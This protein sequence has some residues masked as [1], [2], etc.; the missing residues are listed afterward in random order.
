[1]EEVALVVGGEGAPEGF[2]LKAP[3]FDD[4]GEGAEAVFLGVEAVLEK[5]AVGSADG[6]ARAGDGGQAVAGEGGDE[7]GVAE[8]D[9]EGIDGVAPL[10]LDEDFGGYAEGLAKE[11]QSLIDE[12]GAEVEEDAGALARGFAPAGWVDVGTPAVEGGLKVGY[13]A[14][15]FF[16]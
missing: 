11:E 9:G 15:F 14:E 10:A 16:K 4:L 13:L 1:M 8:A 12:M 2:R 6:V 7:A 5:V 3:G